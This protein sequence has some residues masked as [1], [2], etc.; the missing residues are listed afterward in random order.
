[1][2]EVRAAFPGVVIN[3]REEPDGGAV[4]FVESVDPGEQ[5]QQRS[6]WI[7]FRITFQYP[8]SDVYPHFV[9]DDLARVDGAG[10]GEGMTVTTFEDRQAVQISRRSNKLNPAHDTAVIKLHKVLAWLRAR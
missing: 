3:V 8:Y 5:Y 9:R 10:L 2:E 1:M 6:T 4:V 7:G